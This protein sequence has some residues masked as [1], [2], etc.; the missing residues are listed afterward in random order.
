MV[1]R[2][3]VRD[4]MPAFFDLLRDENGSRPST[5]VLPAILYS[6]ISTLTWTATV[7]LDGF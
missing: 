4:A 6:S 1:N 3:A 2:E 7:A 5:S